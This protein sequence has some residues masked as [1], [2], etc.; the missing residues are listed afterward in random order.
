MAKSVI[1]CL[2]DIAYKLGLIADYVVETGTSGIWTYRKWASGIAECWGNTTYTQSSNFGTWGYSFVSNVISPQ[3]YPFTF[4]E[5]PNEIIYVSSPSGSGWSLPYN[6]TASN[7]GALQ[8]VRSASGGSNVIWQIRYHVRG[9]W[10]QLGG[11][12]NHRFF[13]R[14][15]PC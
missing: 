10:K 9:L 6:G 2:K 11:V 14:W 4:V 8:V 12:V 3:A 7:S 5:K 13:R 15:F 1:Q